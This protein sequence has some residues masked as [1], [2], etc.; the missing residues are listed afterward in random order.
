[1]AALALNPHGP[2]SASFCGRAGAPIY[3]SVSCV[4]WGHSDGCCSTS[5]LHAPSPV[6]CSPHQDSHHP[7]RGDRA[8]LG[9]GLL[10]I[11]LVYKLRLLSVLSLGK[12]SCLALF[13]SATGESIGMTEIIWPKFWG[14]GVHKLLGCVFW[15]TGT[16]RVSVG[17]WQP[18]GFAVL[19]QNGLKFWRFLKQN[20]QTKNKHKKLIQKN[21][22]GPWHIGDIHRCA[23]TD[24]ED[25]EGKKSLLIL[26]NCLPG[27]SALP[28]KAS[29][30]LSQTQSNAAFE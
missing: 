2:I 20:Q 26:I 21:P 27:F 4:T 18:V 25:L 6:G 30:A 5:N 14:E 12:Q 16:Q 28:Y 7:L 9:L 10:L 8:A 29:G 22:R 17:P 3:S 24:L 23:A 19:L 13:S 11:P 1:M 15:K